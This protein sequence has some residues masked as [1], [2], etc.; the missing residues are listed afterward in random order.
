[1]KITRDYLKSIIQECLNEILL[2]ADKPETIAPDEDPKVKKLRHDVEIKKQA[3]EREKQ[4]SLNVSLSAAKKKR[5]DAADLDA[6][7][8][9]DAEVKNITDK[10]TASK[11][12]MNAAIKSAST[13]K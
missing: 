13:I 1:M 6:K 3:V 7:K 9:V 8:A 5:T 10:I 2:E 4:K 11:A 12:T